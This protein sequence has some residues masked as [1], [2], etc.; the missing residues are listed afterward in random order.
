MRMEYDLRH[1][2][3]KIEFLAGIA[4]ADSMEIDGII[5]DDDRKRRIVVL[6]ILDVSKR[7]SRS[8]LEQI[9]FSVTRG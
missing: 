3:M 5:V 8:P 7:I 1:E 4:M 6:E 9:D 2:V